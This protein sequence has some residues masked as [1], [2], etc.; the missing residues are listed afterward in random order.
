M[1]FGIFL[2]ELQ[3]PGFNFLR[4]FQG[5]IHHLSPLMYCSTEAEAGYIGLALNHIFKEIKRYVVNKTL[6]ET[7]ERFKPPSLLTYSAFLTIAK[8]I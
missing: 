4:F 6:F 1:Q 2:F 3:I 8:V 7:D 5:A